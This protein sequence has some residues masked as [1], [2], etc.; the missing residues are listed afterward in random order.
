MNANKKHLVRLLLSLILTLVLIGNIK[1]GELFDVFGQSSTS[2]DIVIEV[3][4]YYTVE[5]TTLSD[6]T[7][8]AK[9]IIC[10]LYTSPSPR[11]RQK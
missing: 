9:G 7:A 2:G 8:A 5:Y 6:G 1:G 3:N 10:L 4:P 11:D